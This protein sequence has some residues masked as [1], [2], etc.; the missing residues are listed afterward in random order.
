[1]VTRKA[2][3]CQIRI[4]QKCVEDISPSQKVYI[5]PKRTQQAQNE[6]R[7]GTKVLIVEKH[8]KLRDP[9]AKGTMFLNDY[10]HI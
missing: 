8:L 5:S 6:V 3:N 9:I 2:Q 1:M 7:Y 4:I 10:G